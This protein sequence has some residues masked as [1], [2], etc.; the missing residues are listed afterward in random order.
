M[1]SGRGLHDRP[2]G[3][4]GGGSG[5]DPTES[6]AR[7]ATLHE[8]DLRAIRWAPGT[9]RCW[10]PEPADVDVKLSYPAAIRCREK[11]RGDAGHDCIDEHLRAGWRERISRDRV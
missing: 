8:Q 5:P 10:S 6:D 3:A 4:S 11:D 2:H 9:L 1:A 7:I